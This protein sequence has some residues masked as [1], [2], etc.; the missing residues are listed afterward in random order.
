MSLQEFSH[1]Q[2]HQELEPTQ[3]HVTHTSR[4]KGEPDSWSSFIQVLESELQEL[5]GRIT[6]RREISVV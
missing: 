6:G 1:S 3:P 2:S 5:Q 4:T